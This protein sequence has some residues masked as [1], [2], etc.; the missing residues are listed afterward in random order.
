MAAPEDATIRRRPAPRR[1]RAALLLGG[2]LLALGLGGTLGWRLWPGPAGEAVQAPPAALPAALP[3]PAPAAPPATAW[4]TEAEALRLR[5]SA[6]Q[7]LRL[8]EAPGVFLLIFPD[9]EV[10]GAGLNRVAALV[11]K[12]GL[13]RDR[14][15]DEAELAA[16]IAESGD[17]AASWY[18]GHDYRA[19]DLARFFALAARD[20]I[21]LSAAE[22]WVEARL[23]EAMAQ[24]PPGAP[25]ALI[26]IAGPAA[27]LE[28]ALRAT[29]LR[30]EI[31]HGLYFTRP[32]F[33][34]HVR[35]IW[36]DGFTAAER[37]AFRGFLGREGYDTGNE[38]LMANEA[39]AY[40]LFTPHPRFFTPALVGMTEAGVERLR[41]LL[42]AGLSVPG[43]IPAAR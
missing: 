24:L 2:G 14:L 34:A 27:P 16:A 28:E 40:L 21:A 13:P 23:A 29:I 38:D 42:R 15:L 12:A 17:T 26:S 6:P 10:Q 33:A 25:L 30:H 43:D 4:T 11:E 32:A 7:M 8:A 18:L 22:R 41:G 36:Q 31:G 5:P 9:F 37:D 19:A 39:Q 3:A 20:G 1:P 35:R